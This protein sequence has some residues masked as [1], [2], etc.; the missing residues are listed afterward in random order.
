MMKQKTKDVSYVGILAGVALVLAALAL[1]IGNLIV[2]SQKT[3]TPPF[4]RA[5]ASTVKIT[6]PNGGYG[7]GVV[8]SA[9]GLILTNAHVC[10]TSTEFKVLRSDGEK[11]NATKLWIST[12]DYDLCLIKTHDVEWLPPVKL[13]WTPAIFATAEVQYGDEITVIGNP[14]GLN[15]V[16][17]RGII[18]HPAQTVG[19]TMTTRIQ[20]DA[21][22]GPG[23]SGGPLFNADY[24]LIGINHMGRT[25]RGVTAGW[26]F[27]IPLSMIREVL[28]Q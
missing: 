18:S 16:V 12:D 9:K 8:V 26:N 3:V 4:E 28:A 23:N 2:L 20:V 21:V 11:V 7:S 24:E 5:L 25:M 10:G 6:I 15:F 22:V 19:Y 17:T 1:P 27:A 14:M 13:E